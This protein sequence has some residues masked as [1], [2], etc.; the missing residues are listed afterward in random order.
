MISKRM[1]YGTWHEFVGRLRAKWGQ[2]N[3]NELEHFRGNVKA[4]AGYI[5]RHTGEAQG[6][7]HAIPR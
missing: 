1:A 5:E 6:I 4:L 3:Q 7:G 2:L